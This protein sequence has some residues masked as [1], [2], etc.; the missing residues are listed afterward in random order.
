[1]A[2]RLRYS[3]AGSRAR[4]RGFYDLLSI[5]IGA[6]IAI[7]FATVGLWEKRQ[8]MLSEQMA[9]QGGV[10]LDIGN[11]V[12]GKY[13][14]L[15]YSN[16][17]N[18]TAIAGVAN[19]YAP[20]MAELQAINV[21]PS[22]FSTVSAYGAP[23][24]VALAKIPSGCVAP[25]CDIGG[26]VYIGGAIT[27][28]STGKPMTLE[29][30]AAAI[31]G[32]GG[33]SDTI[34]P[35]T[36]TGMNGSWA[37]A[38]PLGN[39]AGVLA[40]RVGY[41]SSGWSAYVRRDGSLP[42]EGDLSFK[43]TTG[44]T[45]NINNV[46]TVN[47]NLVNS[48][49]VA[50]NGLDA[51]DVPAGWSG[52]IRTADVVANGMVGAGYGKGNPSGSNFYQQAFA[53]GISHNAGDPGG[54]GYLWANGNADIG[55]NLHV[56]QTAT[57]AK[58]IATD[59]YDPN[60]FPAGYAGGV[61]TWDVSAGGTVGVGSNPTTAFAAGMNNTGQIWANG[62]ITANEY[63]QLNGWAT[64]GA[65][66]SATGLFG[67][68]GTG[69][70]FCVAGVWTAPSDQA[71]RCIQYDSYWA[72]GILQNHN[73]TIFNSPSDISYGSEGNGWMARCQYS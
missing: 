50:T 39:A 46:A 72:S 42:M 12:N 30:A 37:D 18:G 52:G 32:D 3:F 7:A 26:V 48:G 8:E 71:W 15:Y 5:G 64:Q 47:A 69:P 28:P 44:D 2:S 53:G 45:H 13:L 58:N 34:T 17:V 16:L 61:R 29:D 21:I 22:G 56:G 11:L 49:L 38:N 66:C 36:L 1:M 24:Q 51:K 41:G 25:A 33:Y 67:F 63:I 23:Y 31:G 65:A 20:T 35:G 54:P 55:Q 10:M 19:E 40:M 43:G 27:D 9:A 68:S 59:G 70:L 14:S 62:R 60:D 4:Q 73:F 57:F 6:T